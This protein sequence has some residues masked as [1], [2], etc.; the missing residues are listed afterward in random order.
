M[1]DEL[2]KVNEDLALAREE[3]FD[4]IQENEMVNV[5]ISEVEAAYQDTERAL[6][7][8]VQEAQ[9]K[10]AQLEQDVSERDEEGGKLRNDLGKMR[11]TN[12]LIH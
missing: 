6:E 5:K 4:K 3:L 1:K 8:R 11:E 12:E 10:I 2:E 9:K 7:A